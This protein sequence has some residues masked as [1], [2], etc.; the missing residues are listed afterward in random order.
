LRKG[1]GVNSPLQTRE[2]TVLFMDMNHKL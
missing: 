1:T 2:N